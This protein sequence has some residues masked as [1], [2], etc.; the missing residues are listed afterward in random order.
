MKHEV[1]S[2]DSVVLQ[3]EPADSGSAV[4]PVPHSTHS[5]EQ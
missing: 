1:V 5:T 3:Y 2:D 4:N